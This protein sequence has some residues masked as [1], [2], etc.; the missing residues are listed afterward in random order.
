MCGLKGSVLK[1]GLAEAS[2]TV[3]AARETVNFMMMLCVGRLCVDATAVP[4]V[5]DR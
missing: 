5:V 1:S 2:A 3:S 4:T